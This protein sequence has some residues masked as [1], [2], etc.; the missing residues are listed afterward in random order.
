M[1]SWRNNYLLFGTGGRREEEKRAGISFF[2]PAFLVFWAWVNRVFLWL[3]I[4]SPI[5]SFCFPFNLFASIRYCLAESGPKFSKMRFLQIMS[6]FSVFVF[7]AKASIHGNHI[8]SYFLA[9]RIASMS[10]MEIKC[11]IVFLNCETNLRLTV[12][13][14]I[15]SPTFHCNMGPWDVNEKIMIIIHRKE[16]NDM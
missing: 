12:L 1:I 9:Q 8:H 13:K 2:Y 4:P 5:S 16:D 7:G 6:C 11:F 10:I 3:S 15:D 14:R